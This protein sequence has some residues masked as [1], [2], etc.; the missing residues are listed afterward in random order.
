MTDSPPAARRADSC[1]VVFALL[2]PSVVTLLYFV[3]L[4]A[5]PAA[6]QQTAAAIGKGIQFGLPLVWV[7]AIQRAGLR[8][9]RPSRAALIEGGLLRPVRSRFA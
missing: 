1:M 3:I 5:W 4:A 2:F 6:V 7:L 9:K 8:F